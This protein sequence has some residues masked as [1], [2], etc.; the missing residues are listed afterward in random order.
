MK[1]NKSLLTT[2]VKKNQAKKSQPKD[3]KTEMGTLV[4][5]P[6]GKLRRISVLV[7]TA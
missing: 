4:E 1:A 6:M 5:G 3:N 7:C 2:K